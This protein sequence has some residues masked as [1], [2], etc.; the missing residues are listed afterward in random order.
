[1]KPVRISSFPAGTTQPEPMMDLSYIAGQLMRKPEY[2]D[3]TEERFSRAIREYKRFLVLCKLFPAI[4]L[5]P[6]HDVDE[7]WHRHMLN[8]RRYADDCHSFF[9]YFL[10]HEPID[11]SAGQ[12]E[13]VDT[14][15]L[16]KQVFGDEGQGTTNSRCSRRPCTTCRPT[17]NNVTCYTDNRP[18]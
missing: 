3:W 10:H 7:I 8:S 4:E 2:S 1:M 6:S 12:E 17:K 14:D 11:G 9:G 13:V 5:A 16:Y 15:S 18:Q